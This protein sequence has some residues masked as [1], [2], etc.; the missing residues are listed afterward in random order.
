MVGA[1]T[2]GAGMDNLILGA[3]SVG[4]FLWAAYERWHKLRIQKASTD[5]TVAVH[6]A[7]EQMFSL[8]TARLTAL[9]TEYSK[10]REELSE[11]RKHSRMLD[12]RVQQ[13]QIHVMRLESMMREKGLTPPPLEM[14]A[15][16]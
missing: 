7:N 10:L 9:E 6:S 12:I 5:S 2:G 13:Y 15:L 14:P 4:G 8:M 1:I 16:G 3:I 11:E